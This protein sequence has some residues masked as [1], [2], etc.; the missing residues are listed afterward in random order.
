MIIYF[1]GTGN[2]RYAA[3]MIADETGDTLRNAAE[4]MRKGEKAHFESETPWVF[5]SPTYA[6]RLP[7]VFEA[8]IR[9][10]EFSGSNM[11]YFLMTCGDSAGD[12]ERWIEKLCGEKCLLCMGML[13]V[14]MP[15]NYIALY[16]APDEEKAREIVLRARPVL[17]DAVKLIKARRPFAPERCGPLGRIKSA[18]INPAFYSRIVKAK[19]FYA[20]DACTGCG[21]CAGACPL[22]NIVIEGGRPHWGERCT[23]CMACI[24][25]CP[26]QAIEYGGHTIGQFRYRCPEYRK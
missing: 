17:A 13:Q 11:A 10:A 1:S 24:C 25:G 15:E 9:N 21:I 2:S 8:F 16:D 19:P 3:Q 26:V 22:S 18:L 12:A 5:V 7:R 20:T 23:H 4:F 14:V 6:W